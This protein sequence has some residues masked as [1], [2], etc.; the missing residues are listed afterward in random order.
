[1]SWM[2]DKR[3]RLFMQMELL[4]CSDELMQLLRFIIQI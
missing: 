1:M 3:I 2:G 4:A